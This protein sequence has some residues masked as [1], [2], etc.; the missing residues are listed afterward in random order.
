[1]Q[2][3]LNSHC[4][5]VLATKHAPRGLF[6]ILEGRHGLADNVERGAALF[7]ERPEK[8]ILVVQSNLANTYLAVRQREEAL[9]ILQ[10]VYSG[11]LKLYGKE[12]EETLR[13]ANNYA[14]VLLDL[15]HHAEAKSLLRKTMPVA[16]RMLGAEHDLTLNFRYIYVQ[17]LLHDPSVSRGDVVE[18]V[19]ILEDVQQ[20][21][22]RV[23]G[24]GHPNWRNLPAHL[25]DAR[26]FLASFDT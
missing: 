21:V 11:V 26:E 5:R 1:M 18:A 17:C 24:D 10:E 12:H 19:E 25:E 9:R 7:V 6:Q 2:V 20:R 15:D 22:R 13:E 3:V 23:F 8:N 14:L 4:E 16:R